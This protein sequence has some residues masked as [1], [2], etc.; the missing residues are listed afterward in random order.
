MGFLQEYRATKVIEVLKA[1]AQSKIA[2]S[3]IVTTKEIVSKEL[4]PGA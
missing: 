4:V 3:L 1:M 2:S